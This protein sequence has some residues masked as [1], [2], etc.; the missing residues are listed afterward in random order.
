MT[1]PRGSGFD[2]AGTA[3]GSSPPALAGISALES[4]FIAQF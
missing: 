3:W 2:V 1:S 4:E